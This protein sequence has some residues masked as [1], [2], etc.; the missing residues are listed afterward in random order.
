MDQNSGL[1][2]QP[3]HLPW[4]D[5]L[6]GIA[7]L[8]V[9]LSHVLI[10]TGGK[11]IPFLSWGDLAV[12]LFM[13]LSGFLMAHNYIARQSKEPWTSSRTVYQFWVRRFFRIAPLY[14]PVLLIAL[15]VG[16]QL[17]HF[18]H[19]IAQIWPITATAPTR[20]TDQSLDNVFMHVSFLFGFSP[21]YA[22]RTA[23][24]DWSIGL[25]MQ[26]Y[27]F[28]PLIMLAFLRLSPIVATALF[29]GICLAIRLLFRDFIMSFQMPALLAIKLYVFL[30]GIWI[31]QARSE[32]TMLRGLIIGAG[33]ATMWLLMERSPVALARLLLVI[34]M[35]YLMN[36]GTLPGSQ[37]LTAITLRLRRVLSCKPA[38]FMGET[39]YSVYLAHLLIAIP[40]AGLCTHYPG[41]VQLR[42]LERFGLAAAIIIPLSYLMGWLLY[43]LIEKPGIQVGRQILARLHA[44]FAT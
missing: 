18:R 34:G 14:Y 32:R 30:I 39:S 6:R 37:A 35:F 36:N 5:G 10:L 40:V 8:W 23:L 12:D 41:F 19:E 1:A 27:L 16:P 3:N 31:A 25:E 17:G 9:L 38:M 44:R 24:P 15:M 28:F 26:F 33:L 22:F 42:N 11:Y 43:N 20:Y 4:L 2:N 29:I 13:L 7:A 21:D